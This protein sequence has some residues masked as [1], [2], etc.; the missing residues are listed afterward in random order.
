MTL[1]ARLAALTWI[2]GSLIAMNAPAN[3][4]TLAASG[5]ELRAARLEAFFEAHGCPRPFLVDEYVDA[6]DRN[7]L[8]YRILPA[9]SVLESTCG[10][11]ARLNN[12]WGWDS[13]RTG[14]RSVARGIRFIAH[15]LAFGR[16]YQGKNVDQKLRIY[17]PK[18]PNYASEVKRLMLEIDG[19]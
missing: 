6:A 7:Q 2:G 11:Y 13:A 12:R 18:N 16:Y 5:V 8:D 15:Q 1:A 3:A 10:V 19:D 17:N 4:P 9:V 14:F